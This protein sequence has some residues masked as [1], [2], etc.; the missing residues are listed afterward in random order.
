M[1]LSLKI[2]FLFPSKST[3][4]NFQLLSGDLELFLCNP[5]RQFLKISSQLTVARKCKHSISNCNWLGLVTSYLDSK[6]PIFQHIIILLLSQYLKHNALCLAKLHQSWQSAEFAF[7]SF[8]LVWEKI[9][10]SIVLL[11]SLNHL[12]YLYG[13]S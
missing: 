3:V 8:V 6:Q 5:S 12:Q 2:I 9:T 4:S 13:H 1:A 11:I 7:K 10:G